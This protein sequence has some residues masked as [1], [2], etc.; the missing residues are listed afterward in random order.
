MGL[1]SGTG[2]LRP[3]LGPASSLENTKF[4]FLGGRLAP[5]GSWSLVSARYPQN[6]GAVEIL[7]SPYQWRDPLESIFTG[8]LLP[9]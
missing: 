7:C 4:V 6:L 5:H 8:Y 2:G 3:P 1:C 9:V